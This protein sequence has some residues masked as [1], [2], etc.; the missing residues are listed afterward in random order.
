MKIHFTDDSGSD[1]SSDSDAD[2]SQPTSPNKT[3]TKIILEARAALH[4]VAPR[5]RIPR[6]LFTNSSGYYKASWCN[7]GLI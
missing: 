3:P 5:Y 4:K 6:L 7:S 1:W 2:K